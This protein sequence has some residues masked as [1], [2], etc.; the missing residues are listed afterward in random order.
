[1]IQAHYVN[2]LDCQNLE[3]IP[4]KLEDVSG[5]TD[6]AKSNLIFPFQKNWPYIF[7]HDSDLTTTIV[8]ECW[9]ALMSI[10]EHWWS[11]MSVDEC[12]WVLMSVDECWWALMSVD[13]RWLVLISVDERWWELM[14]VDEHW[15]RLILDSYQ[16][17][18]NNCHQA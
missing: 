16:S 4:F 10:D 3:T 14:T 11:L 13:E 15:C 7:S 9:W 2:V 12:L 6:L 18:I 1:M 8:D 17:M 5:M